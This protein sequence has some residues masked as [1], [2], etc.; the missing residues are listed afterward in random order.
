LTWS[1]SR[2]V[3]LSF[4]LDVMAAAYERAFLEGLK[5]LKTAMV[6]NS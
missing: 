2:K 4:T 5:K 3:A 1:I 6:A